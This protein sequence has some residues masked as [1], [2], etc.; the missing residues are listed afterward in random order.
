MKTIIPIFALTIFISS[1]VPGPEKLIPESLLNPTA[2]IA[3]V[4]S[5]Q[6]PPLQK[7]DLSCEEA[8]FVTLLNLYRAQNKLD[9]VT[10]SESGVESARWHTQDMSDKNYLSH[11]EPDGRTFDERAH[12]FGFKT[13]AENIAVVYATASE[14]F[15]QWKT[16]AAHNT[17]MLKAKSKSIGIGEY[18]GSGT[19]KHYWENTF[20]P[21]VQDSIK[22]PGN[23]DVNCPQPTTLPA[24]K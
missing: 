5:Q 20:G 6:T 4:L 10:V 21:E 23:N 12:A 13:W 16:S 11:T 19:Y 1:C 18:S 15:C 24:C 9:P 8:R 14:I 2:P 17:N 22:L 3:K 7:D